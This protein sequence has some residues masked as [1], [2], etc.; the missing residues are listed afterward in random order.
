MATNQSWIG[1]C[2]WKS[3]L[4]PWRRWRI[5]FQNPGSRKAPLFTPKSH[6]IQYLPSFFCRYCLGLCTHLVKAIGSLKLCPWPRSA[7]I[8][9]S[10]ASSRRPHSKLQ[11]P[12]SRD[13]AIRRPPTLRG[14]KIVPSAQKKEDVFHAVDAEQK[15]NDNREIRTPAS[16]DTRI[17]I[18]MDS[19]EVV[20]NLSLA[21]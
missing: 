3:L 8:L 13:T 16:F 4:T 14:C 12:R 6:Q 11:P 21:P 10:C 1:C 5:E 20:D 9:L 7:G 17:R 2:G 19:D 18:R 15:Q